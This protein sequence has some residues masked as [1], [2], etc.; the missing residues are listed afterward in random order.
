MIYIFL[1]DTN[2]ENTNILKFKEYE[3]IKEKLKKYKILD[4]I[5]ED[6]INEISKIVFWIKSYKNYEEYYKD[7]INIEVLVK[8]IINNIENQINIKISE[9]K[10]LFEFLI[11]HIKVF[12]F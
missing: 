12:N 8:N 11:Q 7:N 1:N 2:E 5:P 10:L 3:Y 4:K 9:D 6:K